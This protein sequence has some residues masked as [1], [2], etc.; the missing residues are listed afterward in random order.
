MV[1]IN[2][3]IYRKQ[4]RACGTLLGTMQSTIARACMFGVT[5]LA[6]RPLPYV[7]IYILK[8]CSSVGMLQT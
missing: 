4:S 8:K 3:A 1:I 7:R 5:C 2:I 6:E